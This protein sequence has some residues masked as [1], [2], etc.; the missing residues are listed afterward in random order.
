MC[1]QCLIE[2]VKRTMLSRRRLLGG[3]AAAA[4]TLGL[5]GSALAQMPRSPLSMP[6]SLSRTWRSAI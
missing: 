1:N 6:A 4:A 3:G 5:A 2:G